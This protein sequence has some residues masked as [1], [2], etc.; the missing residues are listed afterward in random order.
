MKSTII[1]F[2]EN[3]S[4]RK[5]EMEVERNS[6]SDPEFWLIYGVSSQ[7]VSNYM[8]HKWRCKFEMLLD[9]II[10][11][12]I[13][14]HTET[15]N[16][17]AARLGCTVPTIYRYCGSRKIQWIPI[18]MKN[19]VI[20]VTYEKVAVVKKPKKQKEIEIVIWPFCWW[21]PV[22]VPYWETEILS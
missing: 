5:P 16:V 4:T 13:L 20:K 14:R 21:Y 22:D 2:I 11:T 18:F 1:S 3:L 17:I 6:M 10:A 9:D 12:N 7:T 8:W 15:D 19:K